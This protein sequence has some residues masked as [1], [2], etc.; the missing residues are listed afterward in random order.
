MC[1]SINEKAESVFIPRYLKAKNNLQTFETGILSELNQI[2]IYCNNNYSFYMNDEF[3][4]GE[5]TTYFA[6]GD[7]LDYIIRAIQK[8]D[9]RLVEDAYGTRFVEVVLND[10]KRKIYVDPNCAKSHSLLY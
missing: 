5:V 6:P 2:E 3:A 10:E 8:E 4:P 1:I 9:R 7:S